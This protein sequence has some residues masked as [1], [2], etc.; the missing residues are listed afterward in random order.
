MNKKRILLSLLTIVAVVGVA[1]GATRAYFFDEE[2]SVGNVLGAGT[3]DII[4]DGVNPWELHSEPFELKDMK[5]SYT[6]YIKFTVKNLVDSNPINLW[7]RINITDQSDE[8]ISE[9]ECTEGGGSWTGGGT[10]C[11]DAAICCTGNYVPR[12]N[13]A[14]YILYDRVISKK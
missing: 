8:V 13:L 5:P 7:K 9:P 4:V 11:T 3:I 14:A 2:K 10:P 6:K 1:F 12:N